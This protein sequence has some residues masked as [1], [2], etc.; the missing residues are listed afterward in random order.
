MKHKTLETE[1]P[2]IVLYAIFSSNFDV[3]INSVSDTIG[4]EE[5]YK[6]R[7]CVIKSL[8]T[9][10]EEHYKANVNTKDKGY[11]KK[12][13]T[14][15]QVRDYFHGFAPHWIADIIYKDFPKLKR[16]LPKN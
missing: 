13:K 7:E 4:K 3:L 10:A 14:S 15:T 11:F 1:H 12:V 2:C 8:I 6:H 5:L 16:Y 9:K